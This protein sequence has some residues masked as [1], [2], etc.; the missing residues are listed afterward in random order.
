MVRAV[1]LAK[2]RSAPASYS[3][4]L[5]WKTWISASWL[6]STCMPK[7]VPRSTRSNLGAPMAKPWACG[8]TVARS[9][10]RAQYASVRET[11]LNSA[12]PWRMTTAPE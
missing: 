8:G 11:S 5:P 7:S 6:A 1:A 12:G 3:S 10:P 9:L 2:P 4:T